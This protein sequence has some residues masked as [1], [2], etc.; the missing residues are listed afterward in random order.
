MTLLLAANSAMRSA[1]VNPG[2]TRGIE[3]TSEGARSAALK[4][5]SSGPGRA[6]TISAA[7]LGATA[8]N[9]MSNRESSAG[10][11][12]SAT[13]IASPSASTVWVAP[14]SVA[15]SASSAQGSARASISSTIC[16]PTAPVAPT[17]AILSSRPGA[18]A[19]S[20]FRAFEFFPHQPAH[21]LAPEHLGARAAPEI[22]RAVAL[23][24]HALDR[25]TDYF[26][27]GTQSERVLEQHRSGQD[28]GER[29]GLVAAGNIGGA[30]M[31]RLEQPN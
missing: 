26:G 21:R 28:G 27:F 29:I 16:S 10:S 13:M 25:L 18:A 17:T 11:W 6:R 12:N 19:I 1:G 5:T 14:R 30:P 31:N 7:Q 3:G 15:N 23:T 8:R 20:G 24:Q 22:A 4:S 9:A 2:A